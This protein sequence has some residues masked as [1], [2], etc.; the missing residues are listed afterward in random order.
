MTTWMDCLSDSL[1]GLPDKDRQS[2]KTRDNSEICRYAPPSCSHEDGNLYG[3][4]DMNNPSKIHRAENMWIMFAPYRHSI[5]ED[6]PAKV[7]LALMVNKW[8]NPWHA[9]QDM[10]KVIPSK[11][12]AKLK[13]NLKR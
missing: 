6:C 8:M 3:D 11:S 10:E 13:E 5:K 2:A 1:D 12:L 4:A 9:M 7:K